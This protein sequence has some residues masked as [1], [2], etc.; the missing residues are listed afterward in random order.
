MRFGRL[1]SLGSS[2]VTFTV[3]AATLSA[4]FFFVG[5]LAEQEAFA[6]DGTL[7][8]TLCESDM[9]GVWSVDTCTITA[10]TLVN[11]GETLTVPSGVTLVIA[12][13][14]HDTGISLNGTLTN[15]GII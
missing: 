4:L 7:D 3:T 14:E 13:G 6:V 15:S 9:G 8:Q 11:V 2:L 12:S 5:G 1:E 10:P